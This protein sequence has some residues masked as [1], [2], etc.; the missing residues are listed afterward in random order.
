MD[1]EIMKKAEKTGSNGAFHN[2]LRGIPFKSEFGLR[3]IGVTAMNRLAFVLAMMLCVSLAIMSAVADN[4]TLG[5]FGNANMDETIDED[6]IAYVQGIIGRTNEETELSDANYDGKI[7]E[8]DIAQIEMMIRNE[9]KELTIIDSA[10]RIVTVNKPVDRMVGFNGDEVMRSLHATDKIVGVTDYTIKDDVFFP[11]F[12]DYPNIG[13]T[14]APNYE[15][16]LELQP[17][18]VILYAYKSEYD[19]IQNKL[20]SIDSHITV[21]R[22]DFFKSESLVDEITKIGYI[23]DKNKEAEEYI[24]FFAGSINAIEDKTRDIPE[25]ERLKVYFEWNNPYKAYCGGSGSH[26]NIV[27]AGGQ[28]IFGDISLLGTDIDPEEVMSRDPEIIIKFAPGGYEYNHENISIFEDIR[29]EIMNRDELASVTAV[30]NGRVYVLS[31]DLQSGPRSFLSSEYMAKW[32]HPEL[33]ED[34]DPQAIHQEYLTRFQGLDYDLD[35]NGVF[36]Y[37]PQEAS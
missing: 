35:E 10:D 11:E 25:E 18:I 33:F 27:R 28:N 5:I 37:P 15:T 12:T 9:E 26:Q 36:V 23:C 6:D 31:Q 14:S 29:N 24:E 16:I 21:I 34:L 19:E 22:M 2:N 7:D 32:F 4:Y 3:M 17:D 13:T 8:D 30:K 20:E 1:V